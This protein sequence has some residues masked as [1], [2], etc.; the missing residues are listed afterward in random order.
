MSR[1]KNSLPQSAKKFWAFEHRKRGVSFRKL[2]FQVRNIVFFFACGAFRN[3]QLY[4]QPKNVNF[5]RLRR[6]FY[7]HQ[8]TWGLQYIYQWKVRIQSDQTLDLKTCGEPSRRW[9][10]S[11]HINR[12][13]LFMNATHFRIFDS[14]SVWIDLGWVLHPPPRYS[15]LTHHPFAHCID[16]R[17]LVGHNPHRDVNRCFVIPK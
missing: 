10:T 7:I 3:T 17:K 1:P 6:S 9:E 16:F 14:F 5:F 4:F 11:A 15:A 13:H 2:T 12:K 8:S